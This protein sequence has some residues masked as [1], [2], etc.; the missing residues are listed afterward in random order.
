VGRNLHT[1][2]GAEMIYVTDP[3]RLVERLV[4]R[5]RSDDYACPCRPRSS[6]SPGVLAGP[7]VRLRAGKKEEMM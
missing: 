7:L 5:Y 2:T 3:A 4:E 1:E 6:S